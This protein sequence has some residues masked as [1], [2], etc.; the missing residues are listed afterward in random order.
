MVLQEGAQPEHDSLSTRP[1]DTA[2]GLSAS[3]TAQHARG[4]L[5]ASTK[6]E[7]DWKDAQHSCGNAHTGHSADGQKLT[8][9]KVRQARIV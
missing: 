9:Q 3:D 1:E 5:V 2:A 7:V 8:L 6:R 4:S